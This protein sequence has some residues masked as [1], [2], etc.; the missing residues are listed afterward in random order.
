MSE[1]S[2]RYVRDVLFDYLNPSPSPARK[3]TDIHFSREIIM[4]NNTKNEPIKT[5]N[6]L[7]PKKE[8]PSTGGEGMPDELDLIK[9]G[10]S[11]TAPEYAKEDLK[12]HFPNR[13]YIAKDLSIPR[14]KVEE[15]INESLEMIDEF[16]RLQAICEKEASHN[17]AKNHEQR[18]DTRKFLI[19]QLQSLL[20]ESG[21]EGE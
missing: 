15:K 6:Q 21:K 5:S 16:K 20:D 3:P 8:S 18:I 13:E 2:S 10:E 4:T 17:Q 11:Y 1:K 9:T 14:A 19:A 12:K 7:K